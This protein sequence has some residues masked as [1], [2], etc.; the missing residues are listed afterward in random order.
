MTP[1]HMLVA[2]LCCKK[3]PQLTGIFVIVDEEL[4]DLIS[5]LTIRKLD[6]ILGDAVVVHE[7]EEIIFRDIKLRGIVSPT[8]GIQE[9]D[10][11]TS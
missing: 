6:I 11:L 8:C 9:V 4:F 5:N 1:T 2:Q 10:Q 7:G 3:Q